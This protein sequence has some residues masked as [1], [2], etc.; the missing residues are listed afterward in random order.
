MSASILYHTNQIEHVQ[1]KNITY[2]LDNIVFEVL[3]KP[4][5]ALCPCCNH[6]ESS[7]K[8]IKI[9]KLRMAPLGNKAAFLSVEVHRLKCLNCEH[10]WWPALSFANSKKR[11]TLSFEAYVV[12]LMRFSTI[13]HVAR[14]LG[15]SWGTIKSIHKS[16]LKKEYKSPSFESLQYIGVDEFSIRKGHEYMTIFINLESGEIIHAVEGKSINSVTPFMLQLKESATGLKAIAMDMNAAY[17]S[18][19]RQYLP[20]ID[21]VFDRFH[22]VA[23]LNTAIDEIRRNQ[24]ARC[25]QAGLRAIKGC[26]FL[27]LSNYEKLNPKSQNSLDTLL[28]VNEP[29]ATGHAMKEQIRLFWNKSTVKEGAQF[30]C[31]WIMDAFDSGI[32][33]LRK[34]GKTLLSHGK[35]LLNYFKHRITNGKTEGINNKIKTMK[36]QAYGFRDIEYFKLRLYSLHKTRYSFLR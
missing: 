32:D 26:R 7:L 27:L 30:L 28:K 2:S 18:A 19:V 24:Q 33:E 34:A 23:L 4:N 11:V 35:D 1:V 12:N 15:V 22:V 14:F 13:E 8:G 6:H 16:H 29:I 9:R 31:W 25:T 21:I 10:Q 5:K 36:R 20:N 3:Y 17:A